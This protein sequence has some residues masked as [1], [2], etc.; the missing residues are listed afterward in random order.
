MSGVFLCDWDSIDDMKRDWEGLTDADLAGMDVLVA[1]YEYADYSGWGFALAVKDGKLF[2]ANGSHCSCN[3]L[4]WDG[5]EETSAAA[6]RK[7][8]Y[9]GAAGVK[10][11]VDSALNGMGEV[12]A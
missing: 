4:E 5:W 2:E 9:W 7:R 12:T 11:A 3:G 8:N 10:D 6:L 1:A